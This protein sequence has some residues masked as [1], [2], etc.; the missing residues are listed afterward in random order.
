M[1]GM[2]SILLFLSGPG[3]SALVPHDPIYIEGDS[4]FTHPNGVSSGSGTPSDPYII[5]S[6]EI[7]GEAGVNCIEIRSTSMHFVIRDCSLQISDGVVLAGVSNGTVAAV[8]T[9]ACGYSLRVEDSSDIMITDNAIGSSM[10]SVAVNRSENVSVVLN[11]MDDASVAVDVVSS[12]DVNIS[13]NLLPHANLALRIRDCAAVTVANNTCNWVTA[14]ACVMENVTG[15][16]LADNKFNI[17]CSESVSLDA[18]SNCSVRR[19]VVT[20]EY[21]TSWEEGYGVR[22]S[23]SDNVTVEGNSLGGRR[24]GVHVEGSDRTLV[25]CNY[26]EGGSEGVLDSNSTSSMIEENTIVSVTVGIRL[27]CVDNSTVTSNNIASATDGI[28]AS[29][30]NSVAVVNST[31]VCGG[32]WLH[33]AIY[34]EGCGESQA[35]ANVHLSPSTI[36]MYDCCNMTVFGNE[37]LSQGLVWMSHCDYVGVMENTVCG[38]QTAVIAYR[39]EDVYVMMNS[40]SATE[41]MVHYDSCL[42][43]QVFDN[44]ISNAPSTLYEISPIYGVCVMYCSDTAVWGNFIFDCE[45]AIGT[46]S[47]TNITMF[48]NEIN[49]AGLNMFDTTWSLVYQ[50]AFVNGSGLGL[51][52][53]CEGTQ[54]V[55]NIFADDGAL[56]IYDAWGTVISGNEFERRGIGIWGTAFETYDYHLITDDNLVNG[57]P[58]LQVMD[59]SDVEIEGGE[60]G[61]LFVVNAS[62]VSISGLDVAGAWVGMTV[63]YCLDVDIQGCTIADNQIGLKLVMV[64]N[65]TAHHN[66]FAGNDQHVWLEYALASF[67]LSYPGGGNYWSDYSGVD[68]Y[69]GPDQ[70]VLGPDGFGDTPYSWYDQVLDYYP[71]T[72]DFINYAPAASFTY[73]AVDLGG[74]L[75]YSFNASSSTDDEDTEDLLEMRWDWDGDGTWDTEW[76]TDTTVAHTFDEAGSYDVVLEV[77]DSMGLTNTTTVTVEVEG[78]AI[79]EF[80]GHSMLVVISVCLL[81]VLLG[82]RARRRRLEG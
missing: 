54:I 53:D 26:I 74:V 64:E 38:G 81:V 4:D 73:D 48:W 31:V 10:F 57:K 41:C 36:G 5:E 79:P 71:L 18:C 21:I 9:Y 65:V 47:S 15:S 58:I 75:L 3:E 45:S 78:T 72:G 60:V 82:R 35:V 12:E 44:V 2:T 8:T 7:W 69:H 22:V 43:G 6:W 32:L 39:S 76:T 33:Y 52:Y 20:T 16:T 42:G 51:Y 40:L 24:V 49:S 67:N 50:N 13:D 19:T 23:A 55:E 80:S 14:A 68:L 59:C 56:S 46:T 1:V 61:Q 30:S 17:Y 37:L 11:Q 34:F 63:A 29:Y 70:D 27:S 28:F 62:N 77:R 25:A 66:W